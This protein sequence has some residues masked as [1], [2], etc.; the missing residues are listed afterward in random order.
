MN[1]FNFS[2]AFFDLERRVTELDMFTKFLVDNNR[3]L[4]LPSPE[5]TKEFHRMTI[6]LLQEKYPDQDIRWV[7]K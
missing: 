7:E 2:N 5:Q 1:D 3:S 4:N 6:Q